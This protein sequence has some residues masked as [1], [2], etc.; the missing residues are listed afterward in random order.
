V[1]RRQAVANSGDNDTG[2]SGDGDD[3]FL[4]GRS[5]ADVVVGNDRPWRR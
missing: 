4:S 1:Q 2:G 5:A 3:Q